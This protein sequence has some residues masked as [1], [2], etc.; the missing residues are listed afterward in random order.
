MWASRPNGPT[1][2]TFFVCVF[3]A[4]GLAGCRTGGPAPYVAPRVTGRVL[5]AR[6]SQ[7]VAGVKVRRVTPDQTV[8]PSQPPHGGQLMQQTPAVRTEPDG[9]FVLE[10]VRDLTPFR[11]SGWYGVSISFEHP[12]YVRRVIEYT[13]EKST[14]TATGEPLVRTG[15]VLLAPKPK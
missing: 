5:D 8:D 12:D 11:S 14:N 10:S 2:P 9:R 3:L 1:R 15:D 13:L 4:L 6:T 7:P